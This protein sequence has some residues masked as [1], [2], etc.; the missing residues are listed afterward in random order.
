[1]SGKELLS[2]T[3]SKNEFFANCPYY[4]YEDSDVRTSSLISLDINE[5]LEINA[6][7]EAKWI[8]YEL[9]GFYLNSV[10]NDRKLLITNKIRTSTRRYKTFVAY[11]HLFCTDAGAYYDRQ[12]TEIKIN[13]MKYFIRK[14]TILNE[15][16]TPLI[17]IMI[18]VKPNGSHD[19][20]IEDT[21]VLIDYSVYTSKNS[22]EKIIHSWIIP[23]LIEN[24]YKIELS[25]FENN[26][27]WDKPVIPI[28]I[29]KS[30]DIAYNVLKENFQL[31]SQMLN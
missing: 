10:K 8:P 14:G 7:T 15:N 20:L 17:R 16:G 30:K 4:R 22:V 25:N 12:Y 26:T 2:N 6:I 29:E 13:D 5:F 31:L 3:L 21:K 18:K 1:M 23:S 11:L 24:K 19:L 28:H 9:Y 27:I